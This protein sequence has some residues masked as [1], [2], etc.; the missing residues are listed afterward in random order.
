VTSLSDV[1]LAFAGRRRRDFVSVA[2]SG[3]A[4]HCHS[5]ADRHVLCPC[6]RVRGFCIRLIMSSP[7]EF[8]Y[9]VGTGE[10]W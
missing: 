10:S 4:Y 3:T 9:H 5:P 6:G 7:I 1:L 2:K 8:S